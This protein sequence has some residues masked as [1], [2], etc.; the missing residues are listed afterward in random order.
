MRMRKSVLES[1]H[2]AQFVHHNTKIVAVFFLKKEM[3][4][5][6]RKSRFVIE[7]NHVAELVHHNAKLVAVLS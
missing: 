5:R 6:M 4:L 3:F 1:N 2:I 7:S